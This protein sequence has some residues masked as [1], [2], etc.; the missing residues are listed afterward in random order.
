MCIAGRKHCFRPAILIHTP[1]NPVL[2]IMESSKTTSYYST[3]CLCFTLAIVFIASFSITHAQTDDET[4]AATT[5]SEVTEVSET[6]EVDEENETPE[7]ATSTTE[8]ASG[9]ERATE[10]VGQQ[11][12][13]LSSAGQIRITNL[14]ANI[15]N[16]LDS[17]HTRLQGITG[18]LDERLD[19]LDA[20]GIDTTVARS[21][22]E[23]ATAE[24]EVAAT[25]L[26]R[27]DEIVATVTSG[28]DPRAA[29]NTLKEE[30]RTIYNTIKEA[31]GSL[32]S[33]IAAVKQALN[34]EATADVTSTTETE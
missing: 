15:S 4:E 9:E 25:S 21:Y 11:R 13:Q 10:R 1:D 16:R 23:D 12:I 22:V 19:I 28:T 20:R 14:A 29:W 6:E 32:R 8:Q 18:R 7:E 34:P 33:A 17:Y 30:Y 5:T 26:A 3:Q 24:L 27:I 2:S 31:H